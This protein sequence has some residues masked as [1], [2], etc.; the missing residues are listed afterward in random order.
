MATNDSLIASF[1]NKY[2]YNVWRPETAIRAGATDGNPKT[3]PRSELRPIHPDPMFSKLSL[4]PR[5]REQGGRRGPAT[6]LRRIRTF[7]HGV[8]HRS[9]QHLLGIHLV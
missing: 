2:H 5:Q 3:Q 1:L 8:E 9:A 6:P 7:D 4:K